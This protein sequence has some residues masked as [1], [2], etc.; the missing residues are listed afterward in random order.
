VVIIALTRRRRG[1]TA[2]RDLPVR[3]ASSSAR[4]ARSSS[5]SAVSGSL[6]WGDADRARHGHRGGH[7]VRHGAA[8]GA[9]G[10]GE[11][12]D[13][14]VAAVAG[15]DV[16]VAQLAAQGIGHDPQPFVAGLVA[17]VI[18]DGLEVVEI[19]QQAGERRAG[20]AGAGD[21]LAHAQLQGAVVD[22]AREGVGGR[23]DAG[24]LVGLGVLARNDRERGDR[25]E[26]AEVLV[27]DPAH[28]GEADRQCAL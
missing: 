27:G 5:S 8:A 20:A 15:D 13:E 9:A 1:A 22:E 19:E 17:L 25:L 2:T 18:V 23:R 11:Q 14:L 28:L 10:A 12:D 7:A 26:R 21:L 4:S 6:Q 24:E 16:V 3:L